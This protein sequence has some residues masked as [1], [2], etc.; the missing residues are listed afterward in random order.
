MSPFVVSIVTDVPSPSTHGVWRGLQP[1]HDDYHPEFAYTQGRLTDATTHVGA[2]CT[3]QDHYTYGEFERL[4]RVHGVSCDAADAGGDTIHDFDRLIRA[5]VPNQKTQTY[6][7][8]GMDRRDQKCKA[9]R[10]GRPAR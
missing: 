7:Y 9:T 2:G 3:R 4:E 6:S 1:A 10:P 8:D 5:V